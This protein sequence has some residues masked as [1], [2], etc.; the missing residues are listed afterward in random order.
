M[1]NSRRN[2]SWHIFHMFFIIKIIIFRQKMEIEEVDKIEEKLS[3]FAEKFSVFLNINLDEIV[4]NLHELTRNI[5]RH[6]V[7]SLCT[8][9]GIKL[10]IIRFSKDFL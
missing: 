2:Y 7:A 9:I 1:S 3:E 4:V 6:K 10:G 5:I 8:I